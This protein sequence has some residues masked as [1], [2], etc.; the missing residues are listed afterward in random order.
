MDQMT[1]WQLPEITDVRITPTQARGLAVPPEIVSELKRS[2]G[3]GIGRTVDVHLVVRINSV[4]FRDG[5]L[6]YAGAT[7]DATFSL[8]P[9]VSSVSFTR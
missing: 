5:T 9:S 8:A 1:L 4:M 3:S 6:T 7:E 2:A